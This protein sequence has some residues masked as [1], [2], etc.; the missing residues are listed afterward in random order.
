MTK[1]KQLNCVEQLKKSFEQ[2]KNKKIEDAINVL[3]MFVRNGDTCPICGHKI[4][5]K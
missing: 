4:L 2:Y 3:Y 5:K 1:E